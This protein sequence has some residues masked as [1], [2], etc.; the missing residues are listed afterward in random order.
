MSHVLDAICKRRSIRTYFG[1]TIPQDQLDAILAA[2][3]LS[4][5][6]Q[7]RRPWQFYVTTDDATLAELSHAKRAGAAFVANASAA[8]VVA[9]DGEDID[10][11]VEDE[12]IALAYM[13]LVASDL[14]I[15]SCWVQMHLRSTNDGTDAEERVRQ[16]L[17]LNP[18]Q[19]IVGLL[20]LGMPEQA[21]ATHSI[22]D[23]DF[24]R[25]HYR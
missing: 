3:L 14:G 25:V 5:T 16:A 13:H 4:P 6:S 9:I 11:W 15:G 20:A 8:I 22:E 17:G 21:P 18:R 19:R 1:E 23:A 10:T 7:N 2:G 24:D 12:S